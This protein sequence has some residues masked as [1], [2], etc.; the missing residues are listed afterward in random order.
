M[1][2]PPTGYVPLWCKSHCSFLEGASSPEELVEHAATLGLPALA[3]TDRDGVYGIVRGHLAAREHRLPLL[4]G[5]E[6]TVDGHEG[7]ARSSLVLLAQD[8]RG[9]AHLCQ[10]I[11]VGRRRQPKG[12]SVV[13]WEEVSQHADHLLALWGGDASL[14]VAEPDPDRGVHGT[15]LRRIPITTRVTNPTAG[16]AG[17]LQSMV[18]V[19][20]QAERAR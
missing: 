20:C 16:I 4:I 6:V 7:G 1:S 10:L 3:L 5:A 11:T 19:E 18:A 15:T 9:Y 2:A 13:T 8:R 17:G 14:L 12:A